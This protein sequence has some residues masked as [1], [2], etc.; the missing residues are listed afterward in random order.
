MEKERLQKIQA[1][2]NYQKLLDAQLKALRQKSLDALQDTMAAKEKEMN[3]NLL[4]KYGI[5]VK[6]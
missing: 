5:P 4:K 3:S 2:N 6:K 1:A